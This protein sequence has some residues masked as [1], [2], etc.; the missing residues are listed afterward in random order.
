MQGL[1][2]LGG[3][4]LLSDST[5][6]RTGTLS[7]TLRA[8]QAHSSDPGIQRRACRVLQQFAYGSEAGREAHGRK[9]VVQAVLE[10][11]WFHPKD[12]RVQELYVGGGGLLGRGGGGG[13]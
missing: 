3:L 8:M 1:D 10:A 11:M 5:L 6:V 13:L 4:T 12:V 2:V 9:H 7:R